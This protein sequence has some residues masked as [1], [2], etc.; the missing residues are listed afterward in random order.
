MGMQQ[1][2]FNQGLLFETDVIGLTVLSYGGGQDSTAI[3]L[4]LIHDREFRQQYAP[5]RLL[6][7]MSDTGDE[8]PETYQTVSDVRRLCRQHDIEFVFITSDMGFHSPSWLSLRHFYRTHDTIGSQAYPKTCSDR[9]KI[10]PTYRFLEQWLTDEYGVRFGRKKGIEQ[11]AAERG[12]VK[13]I[14]GIAKGEE[15]R[16]SLAADSRKKWYRNSIEHV[17]PLIDIGWDRGACQEYIHSHGMTV[18]PS[19]CMACPYMNEAELEY[20]RRFNPDKL[21]E[22][23][24]LEAA[25]LAKHSDKSAVITTDAKG[26]EKIVNKNFGVFRLTYLPEKIAQAKEKYVHWSDAK[27]REHRYSHGHCVMSK[28]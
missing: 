19:N 16:T 20:Q 8:H 21:A 23:I 5:G 18:V 9:L 25:K 10:E 6:V 12:K 24:E 1:Q 2:L 26:N 4:K 11:F 3:L 14:L 7:V 13:M 22:L 27:I 15:N 28:F 17:Y